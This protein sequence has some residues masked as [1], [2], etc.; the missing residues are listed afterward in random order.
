V[1]GGAHLGSIPGHDQL[2]LCLHNT[3]VIDPKTGNEAE[4]YLLHPT[5]S[6]FLEV[7]RVLKSNSQLCQYDII[8]S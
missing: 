1:I 6:F 8:L 7:Q 4:S 3:F 5:H 2:I